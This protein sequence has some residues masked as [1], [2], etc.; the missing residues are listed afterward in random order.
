[1]KQGS[2]IKLSASLFLALLLPICAS[3]QR[4][5]PSGAA[6]RPAA[7]APHAAIATPHSH[8][9]TQPGAQNS[10]RVATPVHPHTDGVRVHRANN[11]AFGIS[12]PDFQNVPGLGFD[13]PHLAAISGNRHPHNGRFGA[14]SSFG[15]SGFLLSPSVIVEQEAV[16]VDSQAGAE[17]EIVDD[18]PP[19]APRQRHSRVSR[20]PQ[21]PAQESAS[22]APLPDSPQYVFVRRDGSLVF[23]VAYQWEN[24]TLRYVTP[25]GMRRT[26]G[27]EALD[28]TAT[29]QFN[30]QRGLNFHAP[31]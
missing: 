24:E 11:P 19:S 16:P 31:A 1:M 10:A 27:R 30:E 15:F 4:S 8:A 20:T 17:E 29:Q 23:A 26:I 22:A 21:A 9:G 7:P 3:A 25:E 28:L 6:A 12:G 5:A 18:P 2:V 13:Y 14:G